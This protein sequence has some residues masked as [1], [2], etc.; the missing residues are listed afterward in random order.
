M[1]NDFES[2]WAYRKSATLLYTAQRKY[3]NYCTAWA[4]RKSAHLA[5]HSV[6][7]SLSQIGLPYFTQ[8]TVWTYRKSAHPTVHKLQLGLIANWPTQLYTVYSLGLLQIGPPYCT[9]CTAWVYRKSAQPTVLLFAMSG[10]EKLQ[11][12]L[13]TNFPVYIYFTF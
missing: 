7:L 2:D 6:Q 10:L 13:I 3:T 1:K 5:A 9:Q 11:R 8:C 4:Y 12:G